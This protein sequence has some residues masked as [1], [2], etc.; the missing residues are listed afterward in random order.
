VL[1]FEFLESMLTNTGE[2]VPFD[3]NPVA[4]VSV[5]ADGCGSFEVS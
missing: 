2:Q 4:G 1:G 5:F 3:I